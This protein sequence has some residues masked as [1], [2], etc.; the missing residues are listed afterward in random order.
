MGVAHLERALEAFGERPR[1]FE[2]TTAIAFWHFAR[3]QVDVALVEVGVGG[4]RDATNVVMPQAAVITSIELEHPQ[5]LGESL[6]AIAR[7]KAG[8][9]KPAVPTFTG[10]SEPETLKPIQAACQRQGAPLFQ[11]GRDFAVTRVSCA[12]THQRF[13]L[14]LGPR[15]GQLRLPDLELGL[16]GGAQSG[17]AALAVATAQQLRGQFDRITLQSIRLGLSGV[18]CAG[19]LEIR[20]GPKQVLLDVAHTP[21]SIQQLR[22][23]LEQFFR[24]TPKALVVG[25]LR[26]KCLA[27]FAAELG[28]LFDLVVAAPVKWFRT[29]EPE[30]VQT[31]FLAHQSNVATSTSVCAGVQQAMSHTPPGGLVVIAGSVF[32]VGEAKRR[33]GWD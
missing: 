12:R 21:E 28:P 30:P 11:L 13:E 14:S 33:F 25:M 15:L 20:S 6:E 4:L 26:D 17:N 24:T 22:Q 10:V 32:A 27:S 5:I 1:F 29:M 31:A 7:E 19:R 3:S 9:V 18:S 8:I 16:P 23:Y 2:A